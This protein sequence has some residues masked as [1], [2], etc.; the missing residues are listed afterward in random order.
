M[1]YRTQVT[2]DPE[3]QRRGQRKAQELGI[4]FSE[5]MRRL[6]ERDLTEHQPEA[7]PTLVFDLGQSA[8][9]DIAYD[10]DAKDTMI[11]E[12]VDALKKR[13]PK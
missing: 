11:G 2:L 9:S 12:A 13:L 8:G 5:Y 4:S 1:M 6:L 7:S 10:Q 3:L